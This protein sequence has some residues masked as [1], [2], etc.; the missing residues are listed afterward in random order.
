[1]AEEEKLRS[2]LKRVIADLQKTRQ[3]LQEA[4]SADLE[5]IAVVGMA[6]RFPGGIRSPEDLWEVVLQGR[7]VLAEFPDDRGW[8]TDALLGGGD[9]AGTPGA[10]DSAVGG[11][12]YDVADFDAGFFG[13]SPR[14]ALVMDPQQRL[15]LETAWETFERAGIDPAGLKGS[16]TGVFVG[17]AASGYGVG[18]SQ[19]PEELAG[20]LLT[21]GAGSVLSG[22]LSY[23]YGL[24]GPA[25]TVD[26]ACSS[27]LVA[28]HLAAQALRSGE[29]SLALVGGVSV[30]CGPGVFVEFVRQGGLASDGRC[31]SFSADADGTGWGE[32]VGVLLVERL[33]D[34]RARGHQ[35]LAVIRGSAVNQDGAS[36]GLTAPNGPSQERVIGQALAAARLSPAEVDA[37]EAHGTGTRLGDPIEARA[38]LAAYGQDRPRTGPLWLGSVKSNIGHTQ[39]AAGVAG[40]IKMVMALQHGSLPRT[41]HVAEPTPEV[42]WSA[43][44]VRLLTHEHPWP[45]TDRP[46]R[47]GVSSFGLSGTNAHLVLEQ[48]PET[49][50]PA[51]ALLVSAG[52]VPWVV[53][54]RGVAGLRGQAERL[55][56]YVAERPELDLV[57]VARS[58]AGTRSALDQRA[59]V[60]GR[61]REELLAGLAALAAG[62]QH[63]AVVAG[64]VTTGSADLGWL[65]TGQGS[66]RLGMGRELSAVFPV[67]A[68][69][70]DEVCGL[71]GLDLK[72]VVWGEAAGELERTGWA[73]LG[74]FAL[75]VS[76]AR[77]LGS[78]GVIPRGVAGHSVGEIAAA[79][80]A[81][82]LSL[83]N[84]CTLVSARARLMGALPAGGAM[85]SIRA[86]EA[87]VTE[88]LVS[89]DGVEIAA[90]NGPDAVVVSGTAEA[91]EA[92][93]V[94]FSRES[95][96]KLRVSHAFHSH[97][98]EPML[99]EFAEV[100][101]SLSYG[102][103]RIPMAL[104]ADGR[105]AT[106]VPDADY[107]VRQ[108][109]DTVR[110]GDAVTSLAAEGIGRWVELGPDGTLSAFAPGVLREDATAVPLL[111][112]GREETAT[113]FTALAQ[114]HVKGADV[115]WNELF[116][117]GPLTALPTY[118]FQRDRYW[119]E[120]TQGRQAEDA[121]SLGL[122]PATHPLLGA[123]ARLASEDGWLLTGRLSVAEQP[124]LADHAMGES[125]LFPGTALVELA[126][127]AA[128]ECGGGRVGELILETPMV[129]QPGGD[130]AVQV[131]VGG[132]DADGRRSISV[133]A[134]PQGAPDEE[135][136]VRHAEG[137]LAPT[138][139]ADGGWDTDGS[140]P[141]A[142]FAAVDLDGLYDTTVAGGFSYG[143]AFQGLRAA[144][145]NET[146]VCA[147]VAV[148]DVLAG[149][150][151]GRFLVHPA[152]LDAALQAVRLGPF[153][154]GS[155]AWLP[156][157]WADAWLTATDAPVLRVRMTSV[158]P[159]AIGLRIA[160]SFGRPVA[161]V[162]SLVLRPAPTG[163]LT[164]AAHREGLLG[165]EWPELRLAE[166]G[167][168]GGAR[169][170][171]WAVLVG[172][173]RLAVAAELQSC[174]VLT[175]PYADLTALRQALDDRA[176][177]PRA[178]LV[179]PLPPALTPS[180]ASSASDADGLG[181]ILAA[182]GSIR[183]LA[184]AWTT[185]L[186]LADSQLVVV[187]QGRAGRDASDPAGAAALGLL[188]SAQA[189]FPGGF[190][191]IDVDGTEVSWAALR[192][193]V[194]GAEPQLAVRAG[195]AYGPR[196]VRLS[197]QGIPLT[198]ELPGPHFDPEGT[199][200]V[201]GGTGGLGA[202]LAR[203]LVRAHGVRSLL[204][205]SRSGTAADGAAELMAELTEA[206]ARVTV[207]ACDVADRAALAEVL[208]SVPDDEPLRA[209]VH[210]AGV[211]DDGL[212]GTLDDARLERVL[213]PKV[214]GALALRDLTADR[215]LSAFVLFSS[216][217]GLLGGAGQGGY[218]AANAALDALAARWRAAGVPAV[219]LAWGMWEDSSG[220]TAALSGADRE[221][222][223]RSGLQPL[224]A[225]EGLALFDAALGLREPLVAPVKLDPAMLRDADPVAV[226]PLL[227]GLL[228][229]RA[230]PGAP[231]PAPGV[232]LRRRWEQSAPEE[233]DALLGEF[234]RAESA[235]V[236]GHRRAD[237]LEADRGFLEW[238]F[239]SLTG[240]ELRNRLVAA[241]G[242]RLPA[243]LVFDHP[244]AADLAGRLSALLAA[245]LRESAATGAV[246]ETRAVRTR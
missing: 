74:I 195:R 151:G 184:R 239:D 158:G 70:W 21:G 164:T 113:V 129:L 19:V 100:A 125:V 58:L 165:V 222:A 2:Y 159:N 236:L 84:A 245:E 45:P 230:R 80:V 212:V 233:R 26:T 33:S 47:A 95:V 155:A 3:Q 127:W 133:Y 79:Y 119:I 116:G 163:P 82:V 214:A 240:V 83:E 40:V 50:E 170:A 32:G 101:R 132:A 12:L 217:A 146:E 220:M 197:A 89:V 215:D 199:V 5:P 118:A 126:S 28:L 51:G 81:G 237:L 43:G 44:A 203:H 211:V 185:D 56:S 31:K 188:R 63:S 87:E 136:W 29:C 121:R 55:R 14:E 23:V 13:I 231:E 71:L 96:R 52:V 171:D 11:F 85:A 186:R 182:V 7:D 41:L 131:V 198:G 124:W 167:P 114:L 204:L 137:S 156:F 232:A 62:E 173:D 190:Q 225:P 77:L 48:A 60:V 224:T 64:T 149:P 128:V 209:I 208:A 27:S 78:W 213:R 102:I 218:V 228:P 221:R 196:L 138:R 142:G 201:T 17:A 193:L 202:R 112:K 135:P 141:P 241:T 46:R 154:D 227:R 180:A 206:G 234:V 15:L 9:E 120:G 75:Q 223:S 244:S 109:R 38:V 94:R 59:V 122:R 150:V 37:V 176:A 69:T 18:W 20:H 98:M 117:E 123:V 145:R 97:L 67:F 76:L 92:V 179:A 1:M 229:G 99:A 160:D 187:T 177:P 143:P 22:R 152:V 191:L 54:A 246:Q 111:R 73:Q 219:S 86:D 210:T 181:E 140:W 25:M 238:G 65:F 24:E 107:W 36:N 10:I 235:V 183:D 175:E 105:T 174:G 68:E 61:D 42:D 216:V 90:V 8:D 172:E 88:A 106:G 16:R 189:E 243:T 153:L 35:V 148:P 66:Q 30:M 162:E 108:V 178:V 147:E 115:P 134:R 39:A 139:E 205:V 200:L 72:A 192:D 168:S 34:A 103:P 104:A 130:V 207:A 242:L 169:T 157:A 161:R 57:T 144:W 110:F 226:P 194:G 6:C 93:A 91:V 166:A 49:A 4:R 53:S